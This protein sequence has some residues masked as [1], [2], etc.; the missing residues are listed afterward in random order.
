MTNTNIESQKK[1][2]EMVIA[3]AESYF[4]QNNYRISQENLYNQKNGKIHFLYE[5]DLSIVLN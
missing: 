3:I 5:K 2:L 1:L 4:K